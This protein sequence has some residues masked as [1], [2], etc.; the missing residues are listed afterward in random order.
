M[1][2]RRGGDIAGSPVV[3]LAR[4]PSRTR[5]SRPIDLRAEVGR[6][7][8][9]EA[10]S[11]EPAKRPKR[12]VRVGFSIDWPPNRAPG[13]RADIGRSRMGSATL[14]VQRLPG[15]SRLRQHLVREVSRAPV[16]R[17]EEARARRGYLRAKGREHRE[18]LS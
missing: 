6:R 9:G 13:F 15:T 4:G 10:R 8:P 14:V 12:R 16:D 11:E 7:P 17:G 3:A 5:P 18:K 2:H 1:H